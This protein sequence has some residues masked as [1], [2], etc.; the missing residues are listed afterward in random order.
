M[1]DGV[2]AAPPRDVLDSTR[3]GRLV[4][5]GGVVRGGGY[6]LNTLVALV[7]V[8]LVTRYLGV[9]DFGRFQTVLS[10]IT[11]VGA[12]TDA[13]MGALGLRE[14]AQR[15]G[16]DR[17][18]LMRVLLGLRL[19]LTLAGGVIAVAIAITIGYG[20]DLVLGTALASIG[21]AFIVLQ[22]TLT[23]PLAADLRN[24]ALTGVDVLR[25]VLTVSGY[26]LLVGVGA[27]V[28]AFLGVTVPVG[29]VVAMVVALLVRRSIPLRPSLD[30]GEWWRLLRV[31]TVFAMATAVGTIYLYTAQVLTAVVTDA[32]ATGLF[33]ASFRVFVVVATVPGLLITVAFPLLSRAARD[34][35]E[36]LS[37][38]IQRLVDTTGILGLGAALGLVVGAPTVIDVM[39]GPGFQGAVPAL[40]IQGVTLIASF[41]LAPLGFALLSVHAHRAILAVNLV[42]LVVMLATVTGLALALGPEGAALGTVA[43]ETT[44]VCGYLAALRR[45]YAEI[46]PGF[47]RFLRGLLVAIPCAALA[48]VS[49]PP[50]WVLAC[51]ALGAYALL[52][53]MVR[54]V[55]EELLELVPHGRRP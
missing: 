18:Q 24:I 14:Y 45:G 31:A 10:L 30:L 11:V 7:G 50:A 26:V 35:R 46:A 28:T 29:A 33:S 23:I 21:L 54:A 8:A 1:E 2:D 32:R 52:L 36:R 40:R 43:G 38:A 6:V 53:V 27:G 34:D 41:V 55:P 47:R 49:G 16:A 13:G 4:I 15:M 44:L 51:L 25:Q 20:G 42:G 9:A 19:A 39:A 12:V 17:E 37:Y 5:Q 3:A 48:L 22:T